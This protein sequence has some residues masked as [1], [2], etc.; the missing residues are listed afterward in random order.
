MAETDLRATAQHRLADMLE[1]SLWHIDEARAGRT[2]LNL[3]SA[4]ACVSGVLAKLSAALAAVQQ[5]TQAPLENLVEKY[6]MQAIVAGQYSVDTG[7]SYSAGVAEICSD[8]V[9]QLSAFIADRAQS[10]PKA[11]RPEATRAASSQLNH[12]HLANVLCNVSQ[13]FNGWRSDECWSKW[14]E[15][16]AQAVV[17]IQRQ[18]E[19]VEQSSGTPK[20]QV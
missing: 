15:E 16:V 19:A 9:Q 10:A 20:E 12:A 7:D 3:D 5:E 1:Q 11:P 4:K 14:D 17:A 18:L 2:E 6:R 13:I 8:I